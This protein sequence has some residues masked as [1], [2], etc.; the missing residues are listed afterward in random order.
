MKVFKLLNFLILLKICFRNKI[1]TEGAK[2][3]A[4]SFKHLLNMK[5]L[6]LNL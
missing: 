3:I 2:A 1:G 5:T 6:E 4:D